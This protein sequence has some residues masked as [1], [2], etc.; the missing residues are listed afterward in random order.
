MSTASER[1]KKRR[2]QAHENEVCERCMCR[3][4]V[5]SKKGV[6]VCP[7]CKQRAIDYAKGIRIRPSKQQP[8]SHA[9]TD[10]APLDPSVLDMEDLVDADDYMAKAIAREGE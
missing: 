6:Y 9:N 4:G 2:E 10:A 7:E 3:P 5:R 1:M 8:D